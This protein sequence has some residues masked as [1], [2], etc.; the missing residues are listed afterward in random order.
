MKLILKY[1]V[2]G[3]F[4]DSD[5]VTKTRLKKTG[6]LEFAVKIHRKKPVKV[7]ALL[8]INFFTGIFHGLWKFHLANFQNLK[9]DLG[10]FFF[11]SIL[12]ILPNTYHIIRGAFRL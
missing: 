10:N 6:F 2:R 11:G 8:K 12:I 1:F 7:A 4:I 5:A 3:Y 9:T